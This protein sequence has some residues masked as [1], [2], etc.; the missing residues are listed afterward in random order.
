MGNVYKKPADVDDAKLS[1]TYTKLINMGFAEDDCMNAATKYPNNV[2]N[3]ID[4]MLKSWAKTTNE[5]QFID[6]PST[7]EN[8]FEADC[9]DSDDPHDYQEVMVNN[10]DYRKPIHQFVRYR[11]LSIIK[12]IGQIETEYNYQTEH[13]FK[14]RTAGTGTAYQI[15]N[16]G[17][18]LVLTCA[19][20]IR[21]VI[22]HCTTC[23]T[24]NL[25]NKLCSKCK[26]KCDKKKVIMP[27]AIQFHRYTIT[28]QNF[29]YLENTYDCDEVYIPEA[30][31]Q[32]RAAQK[33]F[34]FAILKF[35]DENDG[36]YTTNCHDIMIQL[37]EKILGTHKRFSI[38]GYP[39]KDYGNAKKNQLYG[40]G[41]ISDASAQG[42]ELTECKESYGN[43]ARKTKYSLKQRVVDASP[44]VS[45]SVLFVKSNNEETTIFGIHTG[46]HARDE[47]KKDDYAF[48]RATLLSDEYIAI[49]K[50]PENPLKPV[51]VIYCDDK[52][53]E[54]NVNEK[55]KMQIKFVSDGYTLKQFA[56][57]LEND[58]EWKED[59]KK[60]NT[61]YVHLWVKFGQI[62]S[63]FPINK[64]KAK[65]TIE[66]LKDEDIERWVEVPDDYLKT[67]MNDISFDLIVVERKQDDDTWPR[68]KSD[69]WRQTL[70][71]GDIVDVQ[72]EQ[73]GW[74]ESWIRYVYPVNHPT[75]AGK[76]IVHFIGWNIKWDVPLSINE[77]RLAKR[78]EH[79]KGPHRPRPK[80]R[81]Y[82]GYEDNSFSF[83]QNE[84][85]APIQRGVV[86]LT[87]LDK[88]SGSLMNSIMNSI[89][90][91]KSS[92]QYANLDNGSI[93]N[94]IIQCLAQS[95]QL[96]D[97]FLKNDYMHH[98]NK[99]NPL[100]F[101]GRVAK[102]F[103]VL[104]HDMFSGKYKVVPLRQ[105]QS[106][107]GDSEV[108]PKFIN[109]KKKHS[110]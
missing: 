74:Y 5:A 100:G 95:P 34:D 83:W 19:H 73:D 29:G 53:G 4:F 31:E 49:M 63:M 6:P 108:A 41:M 75:M 90:Q 82:S 86:G 14:E 39:G 110:K 7:N 47:N 32:N 70:Q 77:S 104:M 59:D 58:M 37:G 20:N 51:K 23:D 97:Y 78:H 56:K 33:G 28:Y 30:Y 88:P 46:G 62:R 44:G 22:R 79:T 98:V 60:E 3:A 43:F 25:L 13:E 76:C 10:S 16:N 65:L 84:N 1:E 81:G 27:T 67:K 21:Y 61:P 91:W 12:C 11:D 68:A 71:T 64:M 96:T 17:Y 107:I 103:A 55:N 87:N 42:V 45:G 15:T 36:Y 89:I 94:S 54:I 69:N 18:V 9:S 8:K 109:S 101:N 72:D 85:G 105:F 66:E 35:Q 24:F 48:N 38:F 80:E 57:D 102:A 93:M 92:E 26:K 50:N 106:V 52:T 2:D 40:Y 99:N